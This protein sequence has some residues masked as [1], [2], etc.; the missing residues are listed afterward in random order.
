MQFSRNPAPD[1]RTAG[2]N[3]WLARVNRAAQANDL[4]EASRLAGQALDFGYRHPAFFN[5]RAHGKQL[6]NQHE[7]ALADLMQAHDMNPRAPWTLADIADCHNALGQWRKALAAADAAIAIDR[8]Y[9]KA[10]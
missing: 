9:S 6:R 3:Q 8:K 7:D 1:S 10:W 4:A 2:V 5:L